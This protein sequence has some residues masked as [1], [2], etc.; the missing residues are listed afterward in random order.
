MNH[1]LL[2]K[3]YMETPII[4]GEEF[5]CREGK[6]C[7]NI[8]YDRLDTVANFLAWKADSDH[9]ARGHL[10]WQRELCRQS[11]GSPKPPQLVSE[12]SIGQGAFWD[13]DF[14]QGVYGG[15][16]QAEARRYSL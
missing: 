7:N 12:C 10:C 6:Y 9:G 4:Q 5:S 11:L 15:G 16:Y 14:L 8:H 2:L 13:L 3:R 1:Y